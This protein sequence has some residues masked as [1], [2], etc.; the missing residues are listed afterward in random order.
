MSKT[1]ALIAGM[2]LVLATS[3]AGAA[4]ATP[5]YRGQTACRDIALT[6]DAEFSATTSTLVQ[7][8]EDLDV[9]ATFFLLGQSL[10]DGYADLV[11]RIAQRH[12][13]GNHS[14]S[15]PRFNRLTAA[16]M[17]AELARTEA[18]V[19]KLTGQSTKPYFRP[20]Y[21]E[22]HNDP[23]VLQAI[24]EAGYSELI[25]WSVDTNDWRKDQT[26]AGV[27][28]A[29]LNGASAIT[30]RGQDPIILMHGFPS[31]TMEGVTAAV[32]VLRE[33]GYQFVTVAELL[34]PAVRAQRDFGGSHYLVQVGDTPA[35]VAAC[36]N[37]S[38]ARLLAYN[39]LT[40]LS[41]GSTLQIP[42]RDEVIVRLNGQRLSF[43]V[44]P[45]I[46][47]GRTMIPV[48]FLEELGAQLRVD[49]PFVTATH[50]VTGTQIRFE[51]GSAQVL[52]NDQVQ[53]M[54]QP[55]LIEQNRL[56]VPLAFLIDQF[57]LTLHWDADL[58]EANL[59]N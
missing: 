46:V 22:G 18:L 3:T 35:S 5:H 13:I 31:I 21:G 54:V 28:A 44:R 25:H 20:P 12:Q 43:P 17:Q 2:L 14:Y 16:Q 19:S 48:R 11:K 7:Q 45:R 8:L 30:G 37:L 33:R 9:T 27:T 1:R 40:D 52:V 39:D 58:V 55:A 59:T 49:G 32:P 36:H 51:P 42:H 34:D 15:H 38:P 50:P 10:D 23:N 29:I 47:E 53:T 24:G 57:G 41:P 26:A 6:F 56:L 4:P